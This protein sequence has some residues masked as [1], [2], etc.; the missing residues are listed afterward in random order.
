MYVLTR[1]E[2]GAF[3]APPGQRASYTFALQNAAT[4][5]TREA[6]ERQACGNETARPVAECFRFGAQR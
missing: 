1:N 3:V 6:A 2:D 4:Y 5:P